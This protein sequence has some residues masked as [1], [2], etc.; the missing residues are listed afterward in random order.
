ME[1]KLTKEEIINMFNDFKEYSSK[2]NNLKCKH[3]LP[4]FPE[5]ISENLIVYIL[6]KYK[7]IKCRRL[8]KSGDI[9]LDNSNIECK[10]VSSKGPISFGPNEK[11]TTLYILDIRNYLKNEKF[12][13]YEINLSNENFKDIYINKTEKYSDHIL[14]K[15]RP[16]IDLKSLLKQVEH[17]IIYNDFINNI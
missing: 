2:V 1:E 16:R 9:I 17:K 13:L 15:R 7:N 12:S 6:N 11:W 8:S 14:Q 10:T 3:R 4:N 5:H